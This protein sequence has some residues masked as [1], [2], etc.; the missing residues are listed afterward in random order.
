MRVLHVELGRNLYGGALQ[1]VYLLRGL[2]EADVDNVLVC[3]V[4]SE[5]AR[6]ASPFSEVREIPSSGDLDFLFPF[7]LHRLI[8]ET[9]PDV[10]HIH[11]RRGADT[12][13][14]IAARTAGVPA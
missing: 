4:S 1:V 10:V 5:I 2:R 9:C 11:S 3:P 14:G 12:W 8:R 6:A 13:G 7:R